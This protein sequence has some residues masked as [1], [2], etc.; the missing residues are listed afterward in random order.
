VVETDPTTE[1]P[2]EPVVIQ[3]VEIRES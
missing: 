3:S 1:A 2:V